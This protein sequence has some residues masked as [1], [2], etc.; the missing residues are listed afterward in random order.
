MPFHSR[1][2]LLWHTA[3]RVE[4]RAVVSSYRWG[5]RGGF[6]NHHRILLVDSAQV[7]APVLF[8]FLEIAEV[9]IIIG[10]KIKESEQ[11]CSTV[12]RR[13]FV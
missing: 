7:Q 5:R 13:T 11:K 1:G 2:D 3:L 4:K 12:Q 9:L 6:G 10:E 8:F